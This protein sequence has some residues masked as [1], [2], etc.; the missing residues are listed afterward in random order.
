M[1]DDRE[2][3][4]KSLCGGVVM[5]VVGSDALLG[6]SHSQDFN[7]GFECR[8]LQMPRPVVDECANVGWRWNWE[9]P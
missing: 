5:V 1:F 2:D 7:C 9:N 3:I 6:H 4:L 8:V